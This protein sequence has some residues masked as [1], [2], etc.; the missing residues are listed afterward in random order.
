MFL[1]KRNGIYYIQYI[2]SCNRLKRVSTKKKSK[3][4]ALKFLTDFKNNLNKVTIKRVLFLED[5]KQ[6]YLEHNLISNTQSYC[7]RSIEPAFKKF[8]D[9]SGNI[10]LLRVDNRLAEKFILSVFS[11]HKSGAALYY[12][13]LKAAFNKAIDWNYTSENP[14]LKVKL[15]KRPLSNPVFLT[16]DDLQRIINH[17]KNPIYKKIFLFAFFT[18]MRRNEIINLKWNSI[19]FNSKIIQIKNTETFTTK[20]K[21]ERIIPMNKIVF[22]LL[23]E[24]YPQIIDI[25]QSDYV[26]HK[27]KGVKLDELYLSKAF[28]KAVR[29]NNKYE[30]V[31]IDKSVHFH[32]LRHSFASNLVQKGTSLYIIKE[33]LGHEDLKTT[34]IYS[35]LQNGNLF[36]AVGLLETDISL[37]KSIEQ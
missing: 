3:S 30:K 15:P 9:F 33:L 34:Q 19:D 24:L 14:F 23:K 1:F 16:L 25:N 36:D 5:F 2:D 32:S 27:Y 18:G 12:R 31:K 8:I 4:E 10:E 20:S 29:E 11:K 26:F 22:D 13:V 35:H 7:K 21:K 17:T 6:E 28:K 37:I